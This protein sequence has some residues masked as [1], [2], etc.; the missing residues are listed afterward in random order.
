MKICWL[1]CDFEK[2]NFLETLNLKDC[3]NIALSQGFNQVE[4]CIVTNKDKIKLPNNLKDMCELYSFLNT[5][6]ENQC[7]FQVLKEKEADRFFVCDLK[8]ITQKELIARMIHI[9]TYYDSHIVHCKK[10]YTGVFEYVVKYIKKIHNKI[11]KSFSMSKNNSYVRNFV[12]FTKQIKKMIIENERRSAIIRESDFLVNVNNRNVEQPKGMELAKHR[13]ENWISYLISIS[14]IV[15]TVW[16]IVCLKLLRPNF[17]EFTWLLTGIVAFGVLGVVYLNYSIANTKFVY[18]KP[19]RKKMK[20]MP[21]ISG[22][23]VVFEYRKENE[24]E[25]IEETKGKVVKEKEKESKEKVTKEK[26]TKKSTTKTKKSATKK[27]SDKETTTKKNV[28]KT[29]TSK[30]KDSKAKTTKKTTSKKDVKNKE[31]DKVKDKE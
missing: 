25:R 24:N 13:V 22:E 10:T 27:S 23:Q 21:Q 8:Y 16:L 15:L 2:N 14:S 12:I 31:K 6:T 30:Q 7:I 26:T 3:A 9:S 5:A 1:I 4:F 29:K 20:Y 18:Y 28:G 17:T 11:V 19:H